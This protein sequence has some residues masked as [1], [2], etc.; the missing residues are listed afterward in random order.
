MLR[1]RSNYTRRTSVSRNHTRSCSSPK[2]REAIS[3]ELCKQILFVQLIQLMNGVIDRTV[4]FKSVPH[5]YTF[6]HLCVPYLELL[7]PEPGSYYSEFVE[8]YRTLP[9]PKEKRGG[10]KLLM[11]LCVLI[12]L[13]MMICVEAQVRRVTGISVTGVIRA[14]RAD[15]LGIFKETEVSGTF[16]KDIYMSTN[17]DGICIWNSHTFMAST[18]MISLMMKSYKES[19]SSVLHKYS[20]SKIEDPRAVLEMH[21]AVYAPV[22][23]TSTSDDRRVVVKELNDVLR[24]KIP[25][26]IQ[27]LKRRFPD[28][29]NTHYMVL[30]LY[31]SFQSGKSHA[32]NLVVNIGNPHKG[33]VIDANDLHYEGD[34]GGIY[35][36]PD[37]GETV[38]EEVAVVRSLADGILDSLEPHRVDWQNGVMIHMDVASDALYSTLT[39][40][41]VTESFKVSREGMKE[42]RR[43]YDR[44]SS[45]GNQ[46][47]LLDKMKVSTLD[48]FVNL[49]DSI[50]ER[51]PIWKRIR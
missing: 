20:V 11:T 51:V 39:L 1:I 40:S 42:L 29:L 19:L 8:V 2:K 44:P 32:F 47:T 50:R 38:R 12:L 49:S 33:Y 16:L 37:V 23:Y 6:F 26:F 13:S 17:Y 3:I 35:S 9:F 27:Q 36:T 5:I 21:R 24:D 22:V 10:G 34:Y 7:H 43:E 4:P 18:A 46:L 45:S 30:S 48:M 14:T 15:Q 28:T 25:D 41:E 31:W